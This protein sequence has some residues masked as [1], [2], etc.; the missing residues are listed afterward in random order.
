MTESGRY[1]RCG[2]LIVDDD[3][4]LVTTLA[5]LLRQHY[6][7]VHTALSGAEA[8][9]ILAR[10]KDIY[11]VLVDLVM[12]MMDGLSVLDHVRRS[13][14]EVSVI[15]MT[16]FGTIETAVDAIKRGA[17]DYIPKPFDTETL[18]KKVSRLMEF[19]ELKERVARLEGELAQAGSFEGVVAG[20]GAMRAV[21]ERARVAAQSSAPVLLVGETGVG[22]EMLARSIHRASGRAAQRFVPINCAAL[23]HDLIE[24][25]LFGYRKGAF[26]GAASDRMGLFR[27]AHGGTLFLDEVAEMPPAAQAKL[28]RV[29]EQGEVRPVG[30][31]STHVVDVRL[32]SATN[33]SLA[34]LVGKAMRDD[35]FFRISTIVIEIPPL[36]ERRED[37]YLL[38][39]HFLQCFSQ[40]YGR[41][42]SIQRAA[43]ERLSSYSFPGNVRELAHILESTV[44]VSTN[45]PQLITE[46]ELTPLLRATTSSSD[47][48]ITAARDF[49]LDQMEKFA[50]RQ[51]LRMARNNKS[52]AA[53]L[54]GISRG[55]LYRK[56]REHG[57]EPGSEADEADSAPSSV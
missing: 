9:A 23:P 55:S 8:T 15:L 35:L 42:V 50:V 27:A 16:G 54:L 12:P 45:N 29:L 21:V 53:S 34:D 20:S 7:V 10:E 37:L 24:S 36:R 43:L 22:K 40:R 41:R 19:Y 56:L 47:L 13:Y 39:D 44:A 57:L 18:L 11:L 48:S 52:R 33:R 17:E 2:I 6:P 32:V 1:C 14:P 30:A 31:T 26:T 49:S 28:L 51:A 4:G 5:K 38:V 46:Q 25:E 3:E